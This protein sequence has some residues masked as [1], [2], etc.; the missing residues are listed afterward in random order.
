[1][2]VLVAINLIDKDL[3]RDDNF[4]QKEILSLSKNLPVFTLILKQTKDIRVLI[5]G[6]T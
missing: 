3:H 1:M 5:E 2:A 6:T 4:I